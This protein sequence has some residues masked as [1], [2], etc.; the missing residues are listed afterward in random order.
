MLGSVWF[1]ILI[2]ISIDQHIK[3]IYNM[4]YPVWVLKYKAKGTLM[5]NK[6]DLYYLYRVHS[7]WN[8]EKGMGQLIIDEYLGRIKPDGFIEP[9]TMRI[10]P[11]LDQTA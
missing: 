3:Y 2:K 5:Q 6:G 1:R 8:H 11:R 10:I 9:K 7:K 4:P